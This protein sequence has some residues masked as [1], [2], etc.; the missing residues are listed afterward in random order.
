M[1][2]I[3]LAVALEAQ[4]EDVDSLIAR[5]RRKLE[6]LREAQRRDMAKL[7]TLR[8]RERTLGDKL[9]GLEREVALLKQHIRTL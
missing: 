6:A 4:P 8:R 3:L 1:M 2:S 7:K 5:E 9:L